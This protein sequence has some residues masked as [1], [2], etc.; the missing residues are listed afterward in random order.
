MEGEWQR[1]FGRRQQFVDE[2]LGERF[3]RVDKDELR[4][5]FSDLVGDERVNEDRERFDSGVSDGGG[6]LLAV[7]D[8]TGSLLLI[9]RDHDG[10]V[11]ALGVDSGGIWF[12]ANAVVE[13]HDDAVGDHR[14]LGLDVRADR[15]D[16]R[17]HLGR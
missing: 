1:R 3:G 2:A 7:D 15:V 13:R 6:A 8:P 14:R 12:E 11:H 5:L 4:A 17:E 9:E 16:V 10:A